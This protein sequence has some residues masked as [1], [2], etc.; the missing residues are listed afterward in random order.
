[1]NWHKD[2]EMENVFWA[3]VQNFPFL[4]SLSNESNV[5][6]LKRRGR[7]LIHTGHRTRL[8]HPPS[9]NVFAVKMDWMSS[10]SS[11]SSTTNDIEYIERETCL[12]DSFDEG[13]RSQLAWAVYRLSIIIGTP[14]RAVNVNVMRV[15]TERTSLNGVR[16]ITIQHPHSYKKKESINRRKTDK[17]QMLYTCSS[18]DV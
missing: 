17:C 16:H 8:S 10:S 12:G 14:R 9:F 5:Y 4:F 7:N 6:I 13:S 18:V 2:R 11:S 15:E 1:M 3:S